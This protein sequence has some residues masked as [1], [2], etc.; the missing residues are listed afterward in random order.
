MKGFK[1]DGKFRPTGNKS[2]SSLK[3]SDVKTKP[4][5]L[6][7]KRNKTGSCKTCGMKFSNKDYE[8]ASAGRESLVGDYDDEC[9]PCQLGERHKKTI[10]PTMDPRVEEQFSSGNPEEMNWWKVN[11]V[12][13]TPVF[14]DLKGKDKVIPLDFYIYTT[15]DQY[16]KETD[17]D[18]YTADLVAV[19]RKFGKEKW[20]E[21]A[22]EIGSDP[23]ENLELVNVNDALLMGD[24]IPIRSIKGAKS[25]AEAINEV[26]ENISA[27]AGAIGFTLDRRLNVFGETGW[28]KLRELALDTKLS[29]NELIDR[30]R[31]FDSR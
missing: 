27:D 22:D 24:H 17:E 5:L 8:N 20:Q 2:K 21:I 14:D 12:S 16:D 1:K 19:P 18:T 15:I 23:K 26:L 3:K 13:A 31:E 30:Q 25:S 29:T 10:E 7:K 6:K 28:D 11:D 4:K 9:Y